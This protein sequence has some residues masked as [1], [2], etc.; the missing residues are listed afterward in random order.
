MDYPVKIKEARLLI[1]QGLFTQAITTLGSILETLYTDFYQQILAALPLEQRQILAQREQDFTRAGDR[2][3]RER[4]FSGLTL[5]GKAKFFYENNVVGE[6]ERLLERPL[7]HFRAFDSRLFTSIRND[8]THD[9]S[10]TVERDEAELFYSQL[11][12]LLLE[13]GF[14]RRAEPPQPVN[15]HITLRSWK[16]NGVVPHD[17]ILHGDLRMDTYAA[18]LWGV[19]RNDPN[20]SAVYLDARKFF[21]QTYLTKALHTLLN[22]VLKVMN[23]QNGDHV[24]QLRTPFG[25]GK[26]H[27]LIALYHITKNRAQIL[28]NWDTRATF[29]DLPDP[30]PSAVA[31]IQCEKF[32]VLKGRDTPEG[33]HINTLWG[34]IAYQLG[35]SL[36]NGEIT[37]NYVRASDEQRTAPSGEVIATL[38]R[39]L[40]RP[41]LILLDE[42]LNHIENASAVTI[43]HSNLGRQ[44]MVFIKN[45]TEEVAASSNVALVYSLQASISEAGGAENLLS[46]LDHLVSRVDA[47]REPVTGA[48]IMNVVQRRLF[49]DLGDEET[50]H[51][52]AAAY[53][54]TFKKARQAAGGLSGD[55]QHRIA[56]EAIQLAERIEKSYPLH[57][58]LLDLMYH[59]WG[60]LPSYQRTRGA[61]QFLASVVSD[62]WEYGRDLQPLI[63][64]GDVPLDMENTRNAFFTQVG[65]RETYNSVMDAD[66]IG[67]S[68][69][70]KAVDSRIASD[71]PTLQRFRVGTRLASGIML[72]SFGARQGEERGVSE[73][74]LI[75]AAI[76][77]GL[78]RLSLRTVLDDLRQGLLYMHYTGRR[79]RFETEPNLNKLIDDETK[80]FDADEV[81]LQVKKT[82]ENALHG[83]PGVVL[84]PESS[85][86]VND[87]VPLFQV[88]FL[89]LTWAAFASEE[90]ALQ[91]ELTKWLEFCDRTRREYKNGLAFAVPGYLAADSINSASR[92]ALAITSL[93]RDKSRFNFSAEQ[94]AELRDR[95][96]QA[97]ER[98]KNG[99]V[100]LYD[101]VAVPT[102]NRDQDGNTK[103]Y[104]W[105]VLDLQSRN[106][107]NPHARVM[108]VL[109]ETY[110]VFD[111]IQPDKIISLTG[112]GSQIQ[113]LKIGDL[114][115]GFYAFLNFTRL[116]SAEA[117]RAAIARGVTDGKFGY[118]AV[119]NFDGDQ[120][121]YPAANFIYIGRTLRPDEIDLNDAYLIDATVARQLIYV[122]PVEPT[123]ASSM[124]TTGSD[125]SI[126]APAP[127]YPTSPSMPDAVPPSVRPGKNKT[128]YT[129]TA[130]A[131][132][133]KAFKLF[134]AVQNLA[135][136]SNRLSVQIQ[137]R[138]EADSGFDPIW[139]R[140]AVE[141]PLD[142]ANVNNNAR[143][144]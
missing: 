27:S 100:S 74:D 30:G 26:T 36:G 124:T 12:V 17:D 134:R 55:E 76:T 142:E 68:A 51:Q 104:S 116:S 106:E 3:A 119:M 24:L 16:E 57:P 103:P 23:G 70:V 37:Y 77:P 34:E 128:V 89:P 112:L 10:A 11:R 129:L 9:G 78:D 98:L 127:Q 58:D 144:E 71:N 115:G 90:A 48:E 93:I 135:E 114:T 137:V 42:V 143:L 101:K 83:S 13:V 67:G 28:Q 120:P 62:L 130:T 85:G 53:A 14:L 87:R 131:D 110:L 49:A 32:D 81:Q 41:A 21:A 56:E 18:N 25:G 126:N 45:L 102:Q 122:P 96:N 38:L 6:A 15:D 105:R 132:K 140:N 22:D 61:L 43:G 109:K 136:K 118:T 92:E 65:Q 8:L 64:P 40:G 111:S 60:S 80:K 88:V 7:L 84:W 138:A 20:I 123:Q 63:S 5:G 125:N 86:R 139:L 2:I 69:R 46:M 79:Y 107:G 39:D 82:L 54:E 117:L 35:E 133:S 113:L 94:L 31:A 47:K 66:L 73:P 1:D 72:Y 141:E 50:R 29:E 44:L 95:G 33:L 59:R 97:A 91:D 52:V 4:G 19:A 75:Q 121:A 108:G 99:I